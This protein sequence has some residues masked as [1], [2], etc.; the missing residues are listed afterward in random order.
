MSEQQI[1]TSD[2]E[3]LPRIER[4]IRVSDARSLSCVAASFG[5]YVAL[6]VGSV[7]YHCWW[8]T[9]LASALGV[10]SLACWLYGLHRWS[11]EVHV[12]E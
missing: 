7:V 4:H 3:Y 8:A 1:E 10:V 5:G 12:M 2:S 11:F 6:D 9:A